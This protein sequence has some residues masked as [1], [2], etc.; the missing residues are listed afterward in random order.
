MEV[1]NMGGGGSYYDRDVTD[2]TFK[3]SAGF[4][5]IAETRLSAKQLSPA[6]N[7]CNRRIAC[8]N[9]SPFVFAFDVTGSMGNL[10]KIIY[11][12][13]PMI[14][15]QIIE[16]GY[17]EDPIVS[18]AGIGDILSDRA[19]IQI[20]DFAQIRNIDEWLERIWLEG[21]GGGQAKESYE[22]AMYFYARNCD[23]K[24]TETPF[25]IITGDEGFRENLLAADL[26]EAFGEKHE[27]VSSQTIFDELKTKFKGNVFL[28]HR[29]YS[30][31]PDEDSRIVTQWEN[32][33]GKENVIRLS[34]DPAIADTILGLIAIVTGSRTLDEYL[35]DMKNREQVS[36]RIAGVKGSLELLASVITVP[37]KTIPKTSAR[38]KT[39]SKK[40][41]KS[42]PGRI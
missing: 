31:S 4:S 26:N 1:K 23:M 39:P 8:E 27:N 3:K 32:A 16:Q 33:L 22:L 10:P 30:S 25:L 38:K 41:E 29:Y 37:K 11:D 17:V 5:T 34:D 36:E 7:P 9:K 42:K 18:V 21:G 15:G 28:I 12:K 24:N 6:L 40:T 13:M 20:S 19:P 2:R 35:E 14:A